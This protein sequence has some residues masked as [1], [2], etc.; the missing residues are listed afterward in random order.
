MCSVPINVKEIESYRNI[1]INKYKIEIPIFAWRNK[2]LIRLSFQI[3][4]SQND[5]DKLIEAIEEI[6]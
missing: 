6:K 2:N 4:N 3:Y 5:V 1:L